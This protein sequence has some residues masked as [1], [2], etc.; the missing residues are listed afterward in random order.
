MTSRAVLDGSLSF[1]PFYFSAER[2]ASVHDPFD[3]QQ[4]PALGGLELRWWRGPG[5]AVYKE[6]GHTLDSATRLQCNLRLA[7]NFVNL[8]DGEGR[9]R[10]ACGTNP[11]PINSP[12][13]GTAAAVS[14]VQHSVDG[15]MMHHNHIKMCSRSEI[16]RLINRTGALGA[17][18]ST[19][20]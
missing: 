11:R 1:L 13:A 9:R 10:V 6:V 18:G 19:M 7:K 8:T 2:P 17:L 16:V 3:N 14:S 15:R 4:T 5:L 20:P 12:T